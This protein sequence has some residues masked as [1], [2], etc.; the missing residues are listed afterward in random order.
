MPEI[1]EKGY[2]YI[3]QPP[4]YRVRKGKK[5][6]YLKDQARARPVPPRARRRR[7]GGQAS[8]GPTL[9]G[10]RSSTLAERFEC[11][12]RAPAKIDRRCD[13]RVVAALR[14]RERARRDEL[15]EPEKVEEAV[16]RSRARTGRTLSGLC[17]LTIDIATGRRSTAPAAS[18]S[19]RAR[20]GQRAGAVIDWELVESAEYQELYSIEEDVRSIGP[21]P[22]F[23]SR[24][25][26]RRRQ[27][28]ELEDAEALGEFIDERGR[29]G[30]ATLQR[31]KGLGEMN[32]EELWETTHDPNARVAAP[33]R[34][35]RRVQTDELFT[36]LMGDQVEPRRDFIEQNALNVRNLDI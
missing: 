14:P 9:S 36:I 11:S 10:S 34:D 8:K 2:L 16:P 22:Y 21:P 17:P 15:R 24:R 29:K 13:A 5:D 3:A 35:R 18:R 6:L 12:A 4:L 26:R 33:G 25:R 20:V 28:T 30:I 31:Y 1:I 32:A 27:E 19:S 23:A 7:A